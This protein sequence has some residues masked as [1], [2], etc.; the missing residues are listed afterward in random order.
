MR[1]GRVGARPRWDIVPLA[2]PGCDLASLCCP[3]PGEPLRGVA[4][5]RRRL[6][7]TASQRGRAPTELRSNATWSLCAGKRSGDSGPDCRGQTERRDTGGF[8]SCRGRLHDAF[9]PRYGLRLPRGEGAMR[10]T[11]EGV[12]PPVRKSRI[13][14]RFG[15]Q[16]AVGE[17]RLGSA[18]ER[19]A[20]GLLPISST[21][22]MATTDAWTPDGSPRRAPARC[23]RRG[24]D[25]RVSPQ[26]ARFRPS[27]FGRASRPGRS[28]RRRLLTFRE[29]G[30]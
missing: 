8:R 21:L 16:R 11:V 19:D 2:R 29:A 5:R 1:P 10:N 25:R 18:G 24:M 23:L 22:R 9:P 15:L 20:A 27:A 26:P 13:R 3:R 6:N 12:R 28:G 30:C 7:G 17:Q 4:S 14:A